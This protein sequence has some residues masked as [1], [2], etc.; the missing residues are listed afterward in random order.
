MSRPKKRSHPNLELSSL[1][2]AVDSFEPAQR[3][4][5]A[6]YETLLTFKLPIPSDI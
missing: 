2:A 6:F 5:P 3:D 1:Y 4:S